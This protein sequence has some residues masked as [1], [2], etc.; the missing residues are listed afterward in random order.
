MI[1][2]TLVVSPL[3]EIKQ[4]VKKLRGRKAVSTVLERII[5]VKKERS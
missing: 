1:V 3:K 5:M 2:Q 4:L